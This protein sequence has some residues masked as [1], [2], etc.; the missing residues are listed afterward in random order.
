MSLYFQTN[1]GIS[2]RAKCGLLARFGFLLLVALWLMSAAAP[3]ASAQS[4][5]GSLNGTVT[6]CDNAGAAGQADGPVAEAKVQIT[7]D[8]NGQTRSTVTDARGFYSFGLLRAA[9]Y[10]VSVRDDA[11][12]LSSDETAVRVGLGE[13]MVLDVNLDPCP[14][15]IPL[16][17]SNIKLKDNDR[18]LANVPLAPPRQPLPPTIVQERQ[19]VNLT[20]G[21]SAQAPGNTARTIMVDRETPG[22]FDVGA[23]DSV[24]G[25]VFNGQSR[26][27]NTSRVNGVDD[28]QIV[29]LSSASF[30]DGTSIFGSFSK[31]LD[32]APVKEFRIDTSNS[33]AYLGTGTGGKV[34][35]DITSGKNFFVGEL[36]EYYR[37]DAVSARNFFDFRDKPAL[38]YHLFGGILAGWIP[39][40]SAGKGN[41]EHQ[42]DPK[43]F[44]NYEG[45]RAHS[46]ITLFEAVPSAAARARAVPAVASLLDSFSSPDAT[47]VVGASADPDFEIF[48]LDSRNLFTKNTLNTRI[49]Y[50]ADR[51]NLLNLVYIHEQSREVVP[52]GVTGRR[53]LKRD[54]KKFG[55]FRYERSFAPF[56]NEFIFGVNVTPSRLGARAAEA[57]GVGLAQ[58]AISIGGSANQTGIEGQP[59]PLS[60]ASPGG[61]LRFNRQFNGRALLSTPTTISFIDQLSWTSTSGKHSFNVGGEIRLIRLS[62]ESLNGVT[63][64]FANLNDFLQNR[65]VSAEYLADLSDPSP[66]RTDAGGVRHAKQQYYIGFAQDKW[67]IKPNELTLTYGLRYEYYT[68]LRE[69]QNRAV[70]FDLS[71]GTLLPQ[72]S[73]FYKSSKFNLLPR[74]AIAWAPNP[75]PIDTEN[76]PEKEF[77]KNKTVFTASFGMHVGPP[78]LLTLLKPIEHDRVNF[79]QQGG[80]FPVNPSDLRAIFIANPETRQLRLSALANGY[81]VPERAYKYDASVK[82]RL[83]GTRTQELFLQAS[84]VG[85]LNRNLQLRNFANRIKEVRTKPDLSAQIIREFDIL[86]GDTVRSPFGEIDYL[87]SGGHSSY[88]SLQLMVKGIFPALSMP[89]FDATYTLARA[90]GNTNGGDKTSAAGNT[91]DY[92]YDEGYS[93]DDIRHKFTLRGVLELPF[94]N[95]RPFLNR[96]VTSLVNHLVGNWTLGMAFDAQGGRPLDVRIERPDVVYRDASGNIFTTSGV[97][98]QPIINVPG[99]GA[100]LN[101]RRPDLIAGVSPYLNADRRLLNP[102]AFAIPA[103]GTF[104]NLRRGVLR[105]P[106]SQV[107]DLTIMKRIYKGEQPVLE[108]RVDVTNL[109]NHTNFDRPPATLPN[110]LGTGANQ[111]QPGQPF[112]IESSGNDFGILNR[113]FRREQDLGSSRQIQFG[114]VI[115]FNGGS[116]RLK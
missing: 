17:E 92:S 13:T 37:N 57:N 116:D 70:V 45:I 54:S 64:K 50:A 32:L 23:S 108:I 103:P 75:E 38:R 6:R 10:T 73:P 2:F 69:E 77:P 104:G 39:L 26:E 18:A 22:V 47:L 48:R 93:A 11:S 78:A 81:T 41:G 21:E 16:T 96:E 76:K 95:N 98:R 112:S 15:P 85:N 63:Y 60:V 109:F 35:K 99:G 79:T 87:T 30:Q 25:L 97:G 40:F 29:L 91:F 36:Y 106:A 84:Y 72:G 107:F 113:T 62:L 52:E 67:T 89:F 8:E 31:R 82:R 43:F 114:V 59:L 115:K 102:A 94:G 55:V 9:N 7:N 83:L 111:L 80:L 34:I 65:L 20:A 101:A 61:L 3:Q 53:Q 74:I 19:G 86:Q 110:V 51:D 1:T 33:P 88:D 46:G 100:S 71:N 14:A 42:R 27:Q 90:Y 49:D 24:G 28:T 66:F 105:G 44:V 56:I 68:A 5:Y 58:A 12:Q 4:D